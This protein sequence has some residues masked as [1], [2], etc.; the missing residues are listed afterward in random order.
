MV[1]RTRRP[2]EEADV[3]QWELVSAEFARASLA[4]DEVEA[5]PARVR[6]H[7]DVLRLALSH[8]SFAEE[9][10]ARNDVVSAVLDTDDETEALPH[11]A[12][13]SS[14][15]GSAHE[16]GAEDLDAVLWKLD[17]ALEVA[18]G[19]PEVPLDRWRAAVDHLEVGYRAAG[20]CSRPVHAARARL[21]H[22]VGD[23]DA[24]DEAIARWRAEPADESADACAACEVHDQALLQRDAGPRAVLAALEPV[25]TGEVACDAGPAPSFAVAAE[26]HARLGDVDRAA[27]AFRRAWHG[28][29]DDP[30][31]AREVAACLRTLVRIGNTDRA[32]DLLLPRL[33][34]LEVIDDPVDR[35]WWAGTTAW[36]LRQGQRSQ[37]VGETV[38]AEDTAVLVAELQAAAADEAVTLDARAGSSTLAD[39]LAD[40]LDASGIATEPTLP[41]TRLPPGPSAAAAHPLVEPSD[42]VGLA[43]AVAAAVNALD[44]RATPLV[45]AWR[46]QRGD[47]IGGLNAPEQWASAAF[48]DRHA[49]Q[50]LPYPERRPLLESALALAERAGDDVGAARARCDLAVLDATE[51][52]QQ[53]H[54]PAAPEAVTARATAEAALTDLES[55]APPEEAAT[56]WRR[57]AHDAWAPDPRA[58]CLHAADLYERAGLPAR[59]ALCVLEAALA[60]IPHDHAAASALIDEGEELAGNT[61]VLRALALDL[62]ARIARAQGD[63]DGAVTLLEAEHG[64]RGLADEVRAGPLFTCCDVLVDLGDWERL[65]IR[66]ADAMALSLR[67]HDPVALA[68]A[69]RLL[70]LAWLEN[71][72]AVEAA[73]LLEAALPVIDEHVPALTGPAGWA[74]GNA[75]VAIERWA[76][77][78]AAFATAAAAFTATRRVE[79]AAHAHLRAGHA[80]W[81]DDDAESAAE[82]YTQAAASSRIAGLPLVLVEALRG[83]AELRARAGDVDSGVSDLDKALVEGERL[84]SVAPFGA[85]ADF[86]AEVLEPDILRQGAFILARAGRTDDAVERLTRAEQLVGGGHELVLRAEAGIVLAEAGRLA[87]AEPRLR[88]SLA[89]LESAGRE[90]DRVRVAHAL[91]DSYERAGRSAEAEQVR[92]SLT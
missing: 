20:R 7:E 30:V 60:T 91:A 21:D 72:R 54:S 87:E 24:R 83:A 92:S 78:A 18:E 55:W 58:V 62:R 27:D 84:A 17:W 73:E 56:A 29:A 74:L 11:V 23:R 43:D 67:L 9:F 57:F 31:R 39:E 88:Q 12:W 13:L 65:E 47:A 14:A 80:A 32:L 46:A 66:A 51:A 33:A 41:P 85:G 86:D 53:Y 22:A 79:E 89:E 15:L 59:R 26:A 10:V 42:V 37:L 3:R 25:L 64:M 2:G 82:Q 52:G 34:W 5:G 8:G 38:G 69:Q 44:P 35:M 49:A 68:V 81:D 40:A 77:A 90:E 1:V 19:S 76:A 61:L 48:L 28:I 70:G 6:A 4:A 75:C 71:G 63:L 50:D 16:L 45:R 36:V